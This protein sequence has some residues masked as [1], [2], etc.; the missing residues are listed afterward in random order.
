MILKDKKNRSKYEV[1]L[2][3]KKAWDIAVK[4]II[5]AAPMTRAER[6][7]KF[8]FQY[9]MPAKKMKQIVKEVAAEAEAEEKRLSEEDRSC[10][11]RRSSTEENEKKK[12]KKKRKLEEVKQDSLLDDEP[13][14]PPPKKKH[15]R[16]QSM[17]HAGPIDLSPSHMMLPDQLT[18]KSVAQFMVFCHKR[19]GSLREDNKDIT[20]EKL[21]DLLK[22]KWDELEEDQQA[23]YIPMG[24]DLK[25]LISDSLPD[26]VKRSMRVIKPSPK[27]LDLAD[28][29]KP[30]KRSSVN[31]HI[32]LLV[33]PL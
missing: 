2:S 13:E 8:T 32:F 1:A 16:S 14:Q 27:K 10:P 26:G 24:P 9:E 11:S 28:L 30:Q 22:E 5:E 12:R 18:D 17:I 33:V 7:Q 31:D 20:D 25:H 15:K 29:Y 21:E 19:R 23:R 4:A 3:R 6:K